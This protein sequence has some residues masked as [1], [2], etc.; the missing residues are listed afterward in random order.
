MLLLI[1]LAGCNGAGSSVSAPPAPDDAA[2]TPIYSVQGTGRSSPLADQQVTVVGV[3]TGDFQDADADGT[4]NLG[5]FFL[6]EERPDGNA[7]SSD[8]IF[9][10]D[11]NATSAAVEI[12]QTVRVSGRVTERFGET[13]IVADSVLVTGTGSVEPVEI[14]LPAGVVSNS[15]GVV[16]AD[17]EN[18]EGM[19]VSMNEPAFV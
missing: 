7:Q 14:P 9:V 8:G 12:Y 18:V 2:I 16:I 11:R 10:F 1:Y 13:Q 5:G 4:R 19:L 15:D 3:V 17:L 6:Q